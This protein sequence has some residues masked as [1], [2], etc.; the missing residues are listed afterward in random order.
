MHSKFVILMKTDNKAESA[1]QI[2]KTLEGLG[3]GFIVLSKKDKKIIAHLP[4]G[5]NISNQGVAE[6]LS[7]DIT[8][9]FSHNGKFRKP[10]CAIVLLSHK[11]KIVGE[12]ADSGKKFYNGA[13]DIDT[14][15]LP[16][17]PFY[18][19]DNLFANVCSASPGY[20]ADRFLRTRIKV[21]ESDATLLIGLDLKR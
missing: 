18:E 12:M 1:I 3:N 19:L 6:A 13:S 2:L 8:I 21:E 5:K 10:P 11:G 9:A 16:P 20:E 14:Y 7:R 17:V 15:I 4:E